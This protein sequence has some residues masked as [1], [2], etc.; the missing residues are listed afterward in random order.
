MKLKKIYNE[1]LSERY[2]NVIEPQDKSKYANDIWDMLQS[3][4]KDIGGYKGVSSVEELISTTHLW[5]LVR[6]G[7]KIVAFCLYKD[8][9][10][11][12]SI[13]MGTDGSPE[14]KKAIMDIWAEDLK[15]SRSWSEVSGKAEHLKLK[16]GFKPIPNK[17][18]EEILNKEILNLNSDG[19]HYTRLISGVPYEKVI[20]GEVP[21]YENIK[22]FNY[23]R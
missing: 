12:K 13:A 11:R 1:L 2:I 9:K 5:K 7:S 18:A 22:D 14:G 16:Q 6:I 8:Y 17:Y 23:I 19:I 4:Y 15:Q 10:G 20:V 3:S 21:G